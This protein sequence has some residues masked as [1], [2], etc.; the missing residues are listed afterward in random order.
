M[1]I[2][3]HRADPLISSLLPSRCLEADIVI[4][5]GGERGRGEVR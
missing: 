4:N 3:P 5:E 2:D 1:D